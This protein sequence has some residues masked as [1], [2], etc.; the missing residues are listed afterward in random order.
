MRAKVGSG[1]GV[2]S[3]SIRP[4]P[5]STATRP[6]ATDMTARPCSAST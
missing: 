3:A 1:D 6:P 5:S 2:T 4:L